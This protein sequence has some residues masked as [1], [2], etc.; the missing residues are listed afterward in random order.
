MSENEESREATEPLKKVTFDLS[1]ES[2]GEEKEEIFGGKKQKAEEE[3][4]K[5]PFE[6]RQAKVFT[7]RAFGLFCRKLTL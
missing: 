2:E 1:D 3:E 7:K 4:G 5:S 6:R